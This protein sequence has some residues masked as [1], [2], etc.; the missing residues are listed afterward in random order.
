MA[1]STIQIG[2]RNIQIEN[3]NIKN[4]NFGSEA[5]TSMTTLRILHPIFDCFG[6]LESLR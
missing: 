3:L 4:E 5:K 2:I 1:K 6:V